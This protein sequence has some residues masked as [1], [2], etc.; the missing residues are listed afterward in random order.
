M[1]GSLPRHVLLDRDGVLAVERD[2]VT[3]TRARDWEW[4]EG[5]V[6]ALRRLLT[7]GCRVGCGRLHRPDDSRRHDPAARAA[8]GAEVMSWHRRM[9][10]ADGTGGHGCS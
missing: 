7:A 10:T 6:E 3:V 4:I 5:A 1:S 8:A 2:G 9:E